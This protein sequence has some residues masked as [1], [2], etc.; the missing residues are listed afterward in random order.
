MRTLALAA[1][2]LALLTF[3]VIAHAFEIKKEANET[4]RNAHAVVVVSTTGKHDVMWDAID[5]VMHKGKG[6][7]ELVDDYEPGVVRR[8]SQRQYDTKHVEGATAYVVH[9]G[10]GGTCNSFVRAFFR[11][12]NDWGSPE[13]FCGLVPDALQ[14]P[15][16]P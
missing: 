14:N 8:V 3:A 13:V 15:V 2:T 12:H 1:T 5:R 16:K 11:A 10:H 9:C 4:C 7:W 6:K